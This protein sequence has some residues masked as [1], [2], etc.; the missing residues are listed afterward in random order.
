MK[1]TRFAALITLCVAALV[2][3]S[4]A[5][6][7]KIGTQQNPNSSPE[8]ASVQSN[9]RRLGIDATFEIVLGDEPDLVERT[10]AEVLQRFL[11]KGGLAIRIVSESRSSGNRRFLLG[12]ESN[13][14]PLAGWGDRGQLELRNVSSEADGFHLR[15]IGSEIAIAGANQRGVLYG[16]FAFEDFVRGSSGEPLNLRKV[17]EVSSR[18]TFL[19][20][21]LT[22]DHPSSYREL[23]E[24]KVEYYARLGMNGCIDGGGESWELTRFVTSDI[25]PFQKL[26]N[27]ALQHRIST[28]SALFQKYGIDYHIMLW[29]PLLPRVAAE[30]GDYPAEALGTVK[31]PWGGDAEGKDRTLCV[32][33][34][35]V[36]QHYRSLVGKFV[37]EYPAVKGF[38]FYNLDG[39]SWLCTPGLC[40][41]CEAVCHD[42]PPDTPHPWETQAILTDLIAQEARAVRADFKFIHWI[43]HFHDEQAEKLVR[44]SREYSALAYGVKNGD[45]DVM[46]SDAVQP[47]GSEFQMLQEVSAEK[48]AAFHA[49]Y[50]ANAHEVVP[51]GLPYPFQVADAVKKLTRWNVRHYSGTGPIPYF[52]QINALVEKEFLW[53]PSQDPERF[54]SDLAQRQFGDDAG[55]LMYD[56]WREIQSGMEVWNDLVQ[57]PLCGSQTHLGLGFSYFTNDRA[58]LPEIVKYYDD[59]M[60][61]F[62]RVEPFRAEGF[63]RYKSKEFLEKFRTQRV[64]LTKAAELS[65]QAI[66]QADALS[67]IDFA[68]Y[69]EVGVPTKK[70]YAELN[71]GPIAIAEAYCRLRVNML[72]AYHLLKEIEAAKQAHDSSTVAAKERAYHDVLREDIRIRTEFIDLMLRFSALTP[73][74][75]RSGLSEKGIAFQIEHM[76][77]EIEKMNAYLAQ[78]AGSRR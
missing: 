76:T 70:Q 8:V 26:P 72:E 2:P 75:T 7:A 40:P 74:L 12:R 59:T 62:I 66:E 38:L 18:Y 47:G 15:Q 1:I 71:H 9:L 51:N 61:I 55:K 3:W 57:H 17:P 67:S 58:P 46:I 4:T 16:V 6:S 23:T 42:S 50:A 54:I 69:T 19:A 24:E 63:N 28:I 52:N 37:R 49:I 60:D 65:R 77:R 13:L 32:S 56:A 29:E 31:R 11:H 48:G 14:K 41:R 73:T 39:N 78:H 33:S 68:Y 43:S 35:I 53:N 34:P 25:F 22:T 44:T 10:A 20:P 45:H 5:A 30:I 27:A 21:F 64:H 36:Q